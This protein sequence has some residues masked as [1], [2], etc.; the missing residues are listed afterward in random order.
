MTVRLWVALAVLAAPSIA[1]AQAQGEAKKIDASRVIVVD[2]SPLVGELERAKL[3]MP[4]NGPA[5]KFVRIEPSKVKQL[6]ELSEKLG[7]RTLGSMSAKGTTTPAML[8]TRVRLYLA[9][10]PDLGDAALEKLQPIALD[11]AKIEDGKAGTGKAAPTKAQPVG[12]PGGADGKP[13]RGI[14]IY[15][16][17][18]S[19]GQGKASP[20]GAIG[21]IDKTDCYSGPVALRSAETKL[22]NVGAIFGEDVEVDV[23]TLEGKATLGALK[24]LE[25]DPLYLYVV[26]LPIEPKVIP[27]PGISIEMEKFHLGFAGATDVQ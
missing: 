20:F 5:L 21:V 22:K 3:E 15:D 18:V 13:A 24:M 23:R 6:G 2:G 12:R 25:V 14:R 7:L 27:D 16:G 19:L 11:G 1:L 10:R 8:K 4:K 9:D 26:I 17:E